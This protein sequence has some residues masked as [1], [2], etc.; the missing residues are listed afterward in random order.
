MEAAA[1]RHIQTGSMPTQA[2]VGSIPAWSVDADVCI[3]ELQQVL[4]PDMP[5]TLRLQP[6]ETVLVRV[7]N[8]SDPSFLRTSRNTAACGAADY[9][10]FF[11][12][13]CSKFVTSE[14]QCIAMTQT[15]Q[16]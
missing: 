13:E 2:H 8:G 9:I 14:M 16:L 11:G 12:T 3:K 5:E 10:F 4:P 15:T 7:L 1:I 6:R